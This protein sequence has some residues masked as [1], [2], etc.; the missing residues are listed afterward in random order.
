MIVFAPG[1]VQFRFKLAADNV[2]DRRLGRTLVASDFKMPLHLHEALFPITQQV[3]RLDVF[4]TEPLPVDHPLRKLDN[5]LLT[6]HLGY[7]TEENYS[8][9]FPQMVEDIRGWLDGKPGRVMT[10]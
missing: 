6:P 10:K 2:C 3:K 7:V 9:Y 4:D 8:R 5:A 1:T